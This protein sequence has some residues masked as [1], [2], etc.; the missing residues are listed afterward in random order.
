MTKIVYYGFAFTCSTCFW[1]L[2]FDSAAHV[3]LWWG[4]F[5]RDRPVSPSGPSSTWGPRWWWTWTSL[6]RWCCPWRKSR[7][8][9]FPSDLQIFGHLRSGL[10]ARLQWL[11]WAAERK[12]RFKTF[13]SGS[14]F[15]LPTRILLT[16]SQLASISW[17]HLGRHTWI[18]NLSIFILTHNQY[19]SAC[20]KCD[21][22]AWTYLLTLAKLSP[23]LTS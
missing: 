18:Y 19:T 13:L 1:G 17:S 7:K 15:L 8:A 20:S 9:G 16:T 11:V 2:P 22:E 14:S 4:R 5:L 10:P 12:P 23:E 6:P 21:G 3:D